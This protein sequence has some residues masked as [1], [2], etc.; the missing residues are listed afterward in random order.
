MLESAIAIALNKRRRCS[1]RAVRLI[2]SGVLRLVPREVYLQ[3]YGK[4]GRLKGTKHDVRAL[5]VQIM[6]HVPEWVWRYLHEFATSCDIIDNA[7]IARIRDVMLDKV[8]PI[9]K[10]VEREFI[11]LAIENA[12]VVQPGRTHLKHASTVT[13]GFWFAVYA[14][15]LGEQIRLLE[16][17][18]ANLKGKFNGPV[19][20]HGPASLFLKDP[21]KF[22]RD[23]LAC[24]SLKPARCS[25][26]ILIP[27]PLVDVIH[28]L[29]VIMSIFGNLGDDMRRLHSTEVG[30]VVAELD[31]GAT[32]SSIMAA[33]VN[34]ITWEQAKSLFKEMMPRMITRY[35]D[36]ISEHQRDLTNSA[37]SRFILEM[38]E[39]LYTVAKSLRR[40][41]PKVKP[42]THRMRS[43]LDMTHGQT[44]SDPLVTMLLVLGHPNAHT[45]VKKLAQKSRRTGRRLFELFAHDPTVAKYGQMMTKRQIAILS[46][47]S[48]YV[49][50]APRTAVRVANYWRRRLKLAA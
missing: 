45:Y 49:G 13:F 10:D 18:V 24:I 50:E 41:L 22:E 6:K 15:R 21:R 29:C 17:D 33:K 20:T 19:G 7:N 38:V 3:E 4:K 43:N 28:R 27:E 46:D 14:E 42:D 25:T 40:E 32:G 12:R 37:S 11:R 5:V 8:I 2:V 39:L 30:E 36:L 31:K 48:L 23:V 1:F 44:I 35:L 34:P 26:Q 16:R 47:P 9:L